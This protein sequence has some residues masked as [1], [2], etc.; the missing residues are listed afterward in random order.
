MDK[1]GTEMLSDLIMKAIAR[2]KRFREWEAAVFSAG[3]RVG[4]DAGSEYRKLTR[5][6]RGVIFGKKAEI[7][8]LLKDF[9][10]YL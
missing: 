7:E 9:R 1:C 5:G 10:E 6:D 3:I 4:F 2:N 8:S